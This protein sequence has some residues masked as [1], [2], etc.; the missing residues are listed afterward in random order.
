G[1][2][3]PDGRASPTPPGHETCTWHAQQHPVHATATEWTGRALG[4]TVAAPTR[5]AAVV[6]AAATHVRVLLYSVMP[7]CP[8]RAVLALGCRR[9]H[10]RRLIGL[11]YARSGPHTM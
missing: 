4:A 8:F 10:Q 5:S 11:V 6:T 1:T 7:P 9:R 3:W 2:T